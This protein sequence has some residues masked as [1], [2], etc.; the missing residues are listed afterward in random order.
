MHDNI[1]DEAFVIAG[2]LQ[3]G[4][5]ELETSSSWKVAVQHSISFHR[6]ELLCMLALNIICKH[7]QAQPSPDMRL[8]ES[9]P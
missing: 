9:L 2:P 8:P 1:E 4:L 6:S 3:V 5:N 7:I